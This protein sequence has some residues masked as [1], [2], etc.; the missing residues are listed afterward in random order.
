MKPC[1]ITNRPKIAQ[2][3]KKNYIKLSIWRGEVKDIW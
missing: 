1:A 2:T 3:T